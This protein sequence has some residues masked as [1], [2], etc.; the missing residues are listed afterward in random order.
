MLLN[1][2]LRFKQVA[3]TLKYP[4]QSMYNETQPFS[5][6]IDIHLCYFKWHWDSLRIVLSWGSH[7]L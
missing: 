7:W 3:Q 5:L 1:G 6:D 4:L 2:L